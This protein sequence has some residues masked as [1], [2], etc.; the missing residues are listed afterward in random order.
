MKEL[1]IMRKKIYDPY[2]DTQ[3]LKDFKEKFPLEMSE[4]IN[5]RTDKEKNAKGV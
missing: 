4:P 5:E 1:L 2:R 3:D